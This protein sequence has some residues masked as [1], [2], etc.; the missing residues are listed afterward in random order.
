MF[1]IVSKIETG[2]F[3]S[4]AAPVKV[5]KNTKVPTL[6]IH[7]DSDKLVPYSMMNELYAASAA[8]VKEKMTVKGA[9]HADAKKKD[10]DAYFD[11]VFHFLRRFAGKE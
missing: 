11:R 10:P 2:E 6:F 4:D 7:G 5:V 9:G 3:L 8:P 1:L